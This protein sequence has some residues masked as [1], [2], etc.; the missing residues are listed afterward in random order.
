M[1]VLWLSHLVPYPPKGGVLQRSYNLLRETAKYHDI[2]L[3][4]FIQ[5]AL[6]RI[7]FSSVAGGLEAASKELS[8]VCTSVQ[9]MPIP[10]ERHSFGRS[11]LLAKS[12]FT[13]HP[14]T[15]NWLKS[16]DM[17]REVC[18]QLTKERFDVIYFDTISLAPYRR[19]FGECKKVLNH[20]N[21]ESHMMLRR[22]SNE[23]NWLKKTYLYQEGIKLRRYERKVCPEFS[24][25]VTCSSLDSKRLLEVT[26]DVRIDEVPNG[27]DLEYFKSADNVED[28]KSLIFA[29][30]LSAYPNRKAAIFIAEELWPLLKKEIKGVTMDIVGADPPQEL[31][32]LSKRD[33]GF[34]VHGFVEDIRPYLDKAAVYVCPITDGGGT[35]LKIL[36][37]LA[38]EKAIVADPTACEG[39][40]VVNDESVLFA[41][42]PEDYVQ[43]IKVLLEDDAKRKA[44]GLAGKRLV[45]ENYSYHSL[46]EK[47][48]TIFKRCAM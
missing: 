32:H 47:L 42:R 1:K 36:D 27:V 28:P 19:H 48:A 22:A 14:Y 26:Q 29:G 35:K 44:M 37:A 13:V 17:H 39:I 2:Y 20:H 18:H 21:I 33:N 30:R 41:S 45:V 9:F 8:G 23:T 24:L 40:A 43:R 31:L 10:S 6:L 46:G 34:R 4:A 16:K 5:T 3:L 38:M 12:F 11:W 15:V 7:C 25:N